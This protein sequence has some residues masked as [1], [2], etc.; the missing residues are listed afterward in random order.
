CDRISQVHFLLLGPCSCIYSWPASQQN[1]RFSLF[2]PLPPSAGSI[3][4]T[5]CFS[6]LVSGSKGRRG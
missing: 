4:I 3:H 2:P 1:E 5:P 6:C